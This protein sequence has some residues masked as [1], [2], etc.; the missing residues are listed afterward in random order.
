MNKVRIC[1][2]QLFYSELWFA[3]FFIL[4][5]QHLLFAQKNDHFLEAHFFRGTILK[6]APDIGHLISGH[7]TGV[8]LGYNVQT[9]GNKEW[10]RAY[11]NPDYGFSFLYQDFKNETLGDVYALSAHYNFYFLKRRFLFRISQGIGM[12]THPYDRETNFKNNAFGSK[13]MSANMVLLQYQKRFSNIPLSFQTGFLFNHF[14]NGRTKF[15]NRGINTLAFQLGFRYHLDENKNEIPVND[16]ILNVNEGLKFNLSLK[17][18]INESPLVGIGQKPFYHLGFYADKRLGRKS[19]LQLGV[20]MFWTLT[21]K[22]YI[23]Y[24]STAFPENETQID[25]NTD[26]KRVGVFVGHELF[27]NQLSIETQLGYYVYRPFKEDIDIYQRVGLKYY[28]N[29][30]LFSSLHLKSHAARAEA[31]EMGIGVRF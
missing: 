16:S 11:Q 19:A 4:L 6:H 14:S 5:S 7:P 3:L 15:P 27:I 24:S 13:F 20:D 2:F 22:D 29:R 1:H 10:H 23:R 31:V 30:F 9:K 25:P 28:Y 26:Y 21:L 12:A 17:S 8:L 18:G